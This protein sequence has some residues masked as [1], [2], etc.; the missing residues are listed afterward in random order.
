MGKTYTK[1]ITCCSD[2]PEYE[3]RDDVYHGC[4]VLEWCKKSNREIPY[5]DF[6][7]VIPTW[8]EL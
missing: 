8:C 3:N 2:C 4:I 1:H 7:S 5:K 6:C